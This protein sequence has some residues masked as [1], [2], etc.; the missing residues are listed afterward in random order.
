MCV[1]QGLFTLQAILISCISPTAA[2]V[3]PFKEAGLFEQKVYSPPSLLP[4]EYFNSD[5]PEMQP[6]TWATAET[7]PAD[8][9]RSITMAYI[10]SE[11]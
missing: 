3:R 9:H 10:V 5:F 2:W 4:W 1:S 6:Q 8:V 11:R 7:R